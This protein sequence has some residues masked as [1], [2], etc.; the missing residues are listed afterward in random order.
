MKN[1][2]NWIAEARKHIGTSE[3]VGKQHNPI[4]LGW[5]KDMGKY[6][7][8]SKA[9]WTDDETPWCGLFV[10]HVLGTSGRFVVSNWFRAGA[11]ADGV[12]MTKLVKPAY[13]CIVTF[14]RK[15]G[16]HVGF[17]VGKD[18]AGNLL[19][20]GGNQ[21]NRVSI[22]AFSPSRTTGYYWPSVWDGKQAL[23]SQPAPH[24]YDLPIGTA[25]VSKSEA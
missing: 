1:E 9:W 14:T 17:V 23:K 15:G 25:A 2:L 19:V 21:G 3:I 20:L 6:S 10:G 13:G 4:L 18:K 11:W 8:E 24:R 12:N 16:G 5:L 7:K 22:A